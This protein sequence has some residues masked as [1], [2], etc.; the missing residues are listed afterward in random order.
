[1]NQLNLCFL[2]F[3]DFPSLAERSLSSISAILQSGN[4]YVADI[5]IGL[6]MCSK[7][8][9]DYVNNWAKHTAD[10][11]DFPVYIYMTS[12]NVYKYPLMRKMFQDENELSD[13]VMWFDDDSFYDVNN[14]IENIDTWWTELWEK[15]EQTDMLGQIWYVP[16]QGNQLEWI[17][18]QP[19][20][21]PDAGI[22]KYNNPKGVP[23]FKF[24]QGAWWMLRS[25]VI[26]QLDWPVLELRHNGGDSMLG[27]AIRHTGFRME[28]F[29]KNMRINADQSGVHSA[30]QRRG[31]SEHQVGWDFMPGKVYDTS[32]QQFP[33]KKIVIKKPTLTG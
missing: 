13:W 17:K 19:W 29:D 12:T 21:S 5:R 8:T 4:E 20:Y 32:F 6:N 23:C 16:V 3:G 9:I 24:C 18:T 10:V 2:S 14:H 1:V 15:S 28:M 26:G 31:F 7:Q 27:E 22:P 25:S 11:H 33:C 30:A